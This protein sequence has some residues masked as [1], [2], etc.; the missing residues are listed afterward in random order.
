VKLYQWKY[1]KTKERLLWLIGLRA[2]HETFGFNKALFWQVLSSGTDA[3][4]RHQ[5]KE[6]ATRHN[7]ELASLKMSLAPV[8]AKLVNVSVERHIQTNQFR[9][10]LDLDP[11]MIREAFQFGNDDAMLRACT[12]QIGIMAYQELKTMNMHRFRD[13]RFGG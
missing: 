1:L 7:Q 8:L 5:I 13:P 4:Y 6:A 11:F 9:I 2:H 12:E 3:R 10:M